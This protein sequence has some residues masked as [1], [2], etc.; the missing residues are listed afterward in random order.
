MRRWA[1]L[2]ILLV[3]IGVAWFIYSQA[4][5][6]AFLA[7]NPLPQ[8]PQQGQVPFAGSTPPGSFHVDQGH[9]LARTVFQTDTPDNARVEIRDYMFPPNEKSTIA[10][11]PGAAVLDVYSGEGTV[12][13]GG[14]GG[15]GE[16]LV[17]STVKSVPA[18]QS[19]VIDN[20]G[21]LPFVVRVYVFEGK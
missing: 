16:R 8:P 5:R 4:N 9:V 6:K 20:R 1:L 18:G 14:Q 11:L 12:S 2:T 19:L 3:L 7:N 15:Q 10:A 13:A 17:P 21:A